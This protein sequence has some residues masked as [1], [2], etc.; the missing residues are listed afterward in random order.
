[1]PSPPGR[2]RRQAYQQQLLRPRVPPPDPGLAHRLPRA[3][4][5]LPLRGAVLRVWSAGAEGAVG[6][7]GGSTG[8]G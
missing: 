1:M 7:L 6:I 3:P 2:G 4:P 5:P 8:G